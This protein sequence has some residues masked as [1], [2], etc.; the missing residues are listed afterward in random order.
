M[1]QQ[2]Q[3]RAKFLIV[4]VLPREQT[5][6]EDGALRNPAKIRKPGTENRGVRTDSRDPRVNSQRQ[7]QDHHD[8][9]LWLNFGWELGIS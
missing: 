9:V 7:G 8:G 1:P 2:Q 4:A 3:H 5:E 6:S